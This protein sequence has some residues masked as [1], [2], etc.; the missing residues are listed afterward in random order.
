MPQTIA[1]SIKITWMLPYDFLQ[2]VIES[3]FHILHF[4]E[5]QKIA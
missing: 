3:H 4:E 2:I 1:G 5:P